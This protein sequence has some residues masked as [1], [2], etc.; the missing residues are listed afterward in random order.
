LVTPG[1]S[2]AK[3]FGADIKIFRL[4]NDGIIRDISEEENSDS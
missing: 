4:Y 2:P 3:K 1:G